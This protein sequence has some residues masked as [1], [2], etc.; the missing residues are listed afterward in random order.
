MRFERYR[1]WLG[2]FFHYCSLFD[3]D[4]LPYFA[5]QK[6]FSTLERITP[7]TETTLR[8]QVDHDLDGV[9]DQEMSIPR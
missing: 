4:S 7:G 3:C 1:I 9:M 8:V 6:R 2:V 5:S